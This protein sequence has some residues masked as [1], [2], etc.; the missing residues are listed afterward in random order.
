M[1]IRQV[2][3]STGRGLNLPSSWQCLV[4][5]G[6]RIQDLGRAALDHVAMSHNTP[7]A[8]V[9]MGGI[10]DVT[11]LL[12]SKEM[13]QDQVNVDILIDAMVNIGKIVR[14][15]YRAHCIFTTITPCCTK[16][17]MTLQR[18]MERSCFSSSTRACRRPTTS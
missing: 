16:N 2:S 4:R 10:C 1:N 6:A 11:S 5:P 12:A 17:G 9:I 15:E 3:D 14:A 8:I 18:S 7:E 13:V